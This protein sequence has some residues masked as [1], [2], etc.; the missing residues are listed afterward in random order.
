M[1][2]DR[3]ITDEMKTLLEMELSIC[4]TRNGRLEIR[5]IQRDDGTKELAVYRVDS[6]RVKPK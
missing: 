6:R 5:P 2:K 1:D 3:Y 4:A